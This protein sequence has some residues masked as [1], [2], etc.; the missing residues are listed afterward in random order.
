MRTLFAAFLL[1]PSLAFAQATTTETKTEV[2]PEAKKTEAAAPIRISLD[3]RGEDVREVLATLFAQSKKPY[4]LDASIKGKL[5]VKID[6]LPYE[7][8]LGIVLTQ[9]GLFAKDRDGVV[10]I[11][12]TPIAAPA[13]KPTLKPTDKPA[14]KATE[15]PIA[16]TTDTKT[17]TMKPVDTKPTE[18]TA[19]TYARKVTTRLTKATLAD[20]FKAFG[21]QAD[22]TIELDPTVP[23]YRVDA[24]FV[25]TSLKY[26]L[27]RVC[28]AAGLKY[29]ATNG[30]I[31][32][33]AE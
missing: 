21:D 15:K 24:F 9:A 28:K 5:Y 29:T 4:A 30:K 27:N 23:A 17:A 6:A 31:V 3:A 26:G 7:K 33:S 25:K 1:I 8:A 13:A 22:V 20:V 32:V 10:M 14:D 11:S 2:K 19:A 18:I 16:K 12:A